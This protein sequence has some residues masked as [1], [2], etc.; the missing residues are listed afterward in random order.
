[1]DFAGVSEQDSYASTLSE[2]I[3]VPTTFPEWA[4]LDELR[5]SH[6]KLASSIAQGKSKAPREEVQF[7]SA[8]KSGTSSGKGTPSVPG[9]RQD[10]SKSSTALAESGCS[11]LESTH[12]TTGKRKELEHRSRDVSSSRSSQRSGSRSPKRRRSRSRERRK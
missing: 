2:D 10:I 9:P 6:I 1:M 7:V 12:T 5:A 4:Y 11:T 3:A 8:S